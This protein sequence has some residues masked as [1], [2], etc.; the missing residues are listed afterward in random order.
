MLW[1]VRRRILGFARRSLVRTPAVQ[2]S[3]NLRQG[4][5]RGGQSVARTG[6]FQQDIGLAVLF[7]EEKQITLGYIATPGTNADQ[8]DCD[9]QRNWAIEPRQTCEMAIKASALDLSNREVRNPND[10]RGGA[11]DFGQTTNR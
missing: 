9:R 7:Q 4:F 8:F 5:G 11:A 1:F 6:A 3:D 2:A 10:R